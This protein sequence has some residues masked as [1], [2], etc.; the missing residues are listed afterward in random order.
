MCFH[1]RPAQE[2][3]EDL[4]QVLIDATAAVVKLTS[5]I[6]ERL[7]LNEIMLLGFAVTDKQFSE[8]H[9][10]LPAEGGNYCH[11]VPHQGPPITVTTIGEILRLLRQRG[12]S[13]FSLSNHGLPQPCL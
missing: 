10:G 12:F 13:C 6:S 11:K 3:T 4:V 5:N 8:L 2:K 7:T 1:E 9:I